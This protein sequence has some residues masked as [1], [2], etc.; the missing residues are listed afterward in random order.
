MHKFYFQH[1]ETLTHIIGLESPSFSYD[2]QNSVRFISRSNSI[3]SVAL[4]N[5]FLF[6]GL[7]L[8]TLLSHLKLKNQGNEKMNYLVN[9]VTGNQSQIPFHWNCQKP[10]N[11]PKMIIKC[12]TLNLIFHWIFFQWF[13]LSSL[14]IDFKKPI[15]IFKLCVV[16][17]DITIN[18]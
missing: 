2:F 16:F 4:F 9:S 12:F 5:W 8:S 17:T 15:G 7:L 13:L 3:F 11:P 14:T 1:R 10:L 6:S 18:L